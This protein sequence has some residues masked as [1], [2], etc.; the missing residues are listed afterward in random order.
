MNESVRMGLWSWFL[1]VSLLAVVVLVGCGEESP[2]DKAAR[3]KECQE[4]QEKIALTSSPL[5]M[6]W[7]DENCIIDNEGHGKPVAR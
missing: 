5:L 4:T 3:D 2:E 1:G 7:F 6:E